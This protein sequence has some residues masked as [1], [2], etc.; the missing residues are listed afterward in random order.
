MILNL[1]ELG[2]IVHNR[3]VECDTDHSEEMAFVSSFAAFSAMMDGAVISVV[4]GRIHFL[5]GNLAVTFPEMVT[6]E[7]IPTI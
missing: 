7:E 3:M 6:V 1:K 5:R 4:D 2:R